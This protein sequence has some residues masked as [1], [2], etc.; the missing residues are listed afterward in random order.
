MTGRGGVANHTDFKPND[1]YRSRDVGLISRAYQLS[2]RPLLFGRPA[3]RVAYQNPPTAAAPLPGEK[4][5]L[6]A[7]LNKTKLERRDE[8][9]NVCKSMRRSY[10]LP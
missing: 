5:V 7:A 6:S 4:T 2:K 3:D 10:S 9:R 1:R 8:E